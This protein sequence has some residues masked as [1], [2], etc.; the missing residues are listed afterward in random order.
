MLPGITVTL[1]GHAFC[2][3]PLPRA[4]FKQCREQFALLRQAGVSEYD[5]FDA[6]CIIIYAA[7]KRNY[8]EFSESEFDDL[9][10]FQNVGEAFAAVMG[11]SLPAATPTPTADGSAAVGELQASRL[12]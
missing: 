5:T 1:G 3:P 10:T 7:L 6:M 12:S 9:V 2:A 11:I 4:I 8:P